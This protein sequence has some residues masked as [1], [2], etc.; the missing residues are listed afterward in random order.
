MAT[1]NTIVSLILVNGFDF[2]LLDKSKHNIHILNCSS[3]IDIAKYL[4]FSCHPLGD[5][6]LLDEIH[7][8]G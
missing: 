8:K 2:R 6:V 4:I 7:P 3:V 5:I 1:I